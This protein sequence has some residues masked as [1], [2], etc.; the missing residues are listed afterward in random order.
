MIDAM[1]IQVYLHRGNK[2]VVDQHDPAGGHVDAAGDFD[3]LLPTD[4][5]DFPI[6]GHVDPHDDVKLGHGQM[7]DLISEI[8]R[9]L[10]IP[11]LA[12]SSAA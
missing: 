10:S 5:I 12:R 11:A 4:T 7:P 1:G 6:L 2:R 3:R 9:L 8:D